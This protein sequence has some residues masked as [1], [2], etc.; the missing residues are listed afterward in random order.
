MYTYTCTTT[1]WYD[2]LAVNLAKSELPLPLQNRECK[3]ALALASFLFLVCTNACAA[4][5]LRET[6]TVLS[7][8]FK[9]TRDTKQDMHLY[10]VFS[11]FFVLFFFF[12][13]HK[14]FVRDLCQRFN[15]SIDRFFLIIREFI[16]EIYLR[17][18][19]VERRMLDEIR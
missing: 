19:V 8:V 1:S 2:W 5:I 18:L 11:L 14:W 13:F 16:A 15:H 4:V 6:G 17:I 7:L 10:V 9:L 3:V 12:F